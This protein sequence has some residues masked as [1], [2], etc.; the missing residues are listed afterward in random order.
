MMC[1]TIQSYLC[2]QCIVHSNVELKQ[3]CKWSYDQ[4]DD[5]KLVNKLVNNS[6]NACVILSMAKLIHVC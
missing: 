6:S 2:D 5:E 3:P 1:R 4:R